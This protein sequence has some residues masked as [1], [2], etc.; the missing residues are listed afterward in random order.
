MR[1]V[2]GTPRVRVT[3]AENTSSLRRD[4]QDGRKDASLFLERRMGDALPLRCFGCF[5]DTRRECGGKSSLKFWAGTG[6]NGQVCPRGWLGFASRC[7]DGKTHETG[8]IQMMPKR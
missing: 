7:A 3:D 2:V 4:V 5:V 6:G 8:G 1:K